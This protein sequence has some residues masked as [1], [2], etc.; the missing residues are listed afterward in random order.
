MEKYNIINGPVK[1][2]K[3][4][5]QGYSNNKPTISIDIKGENGVFALLSFS[6]YEKELI[7]IVYRSSF[8]PSLEEAENLQEK[9]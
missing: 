6:R 5:G 9:P 7:S 2:V 1:S 3:Y 8:K 4:N